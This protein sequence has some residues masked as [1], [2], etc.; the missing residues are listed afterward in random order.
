LLRKH[1]GQQ[2]NDV[3]ALRLLA[4]VAARL[5]RFTDAEELLERCLE[6]APGFAAASRTTHSCCIARIERRKLSTSST[7]CWLANR[8]TRDC[9]RARHR[10]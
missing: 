1:L 4:E 9:E 6:L 8:A 2:P 7:S 5:G 10:C 3:A